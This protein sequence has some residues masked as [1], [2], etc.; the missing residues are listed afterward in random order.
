MIITVGRLRQFG[1]DD[2]GLSQIF[3]LRR[4]HHR[5]RAKGA[6][7]PPQHQICF[8]G[9]WTINPSSAGVTFNWQVRRE[10][11]GSGS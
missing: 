2:F 5:Q 4:Q 3:G 11:T 8:S 9:I 10:R 6:R 1:P 7:Q